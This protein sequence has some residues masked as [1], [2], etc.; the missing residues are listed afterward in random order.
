VTPGIYVG[1]DSGGTLTNVDIVVQAA[2][3]HER[4]KSYEAP[5]CLSGALE[6]ALIPDVLR[7]ILL[8]LPKELEDLTSELDPVTSEELPTYVWVGA[9]G[10]TSWTRD[11]FTTAL[12]DIRSTIPGEVRAMTP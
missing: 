2:D 1:V 11:E 3:G 8:R 4:R 10:Y 6:H 7:R 9:A 5:E 12:L